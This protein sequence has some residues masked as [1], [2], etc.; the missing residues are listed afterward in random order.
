MEAGKFVVFSSPDIAMNHAIS[1][2][3]GT[4][5]FFVILRVSHK[6]LCNMYPR[7]KISYAEI[8]VV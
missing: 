7:P 1:K 8:F 3:Q 5:I 2:I 6:Y 4:R